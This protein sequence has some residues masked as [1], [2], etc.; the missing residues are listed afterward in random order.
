MD[1]DEHPY[2]ELSSRTLLLEG[3]TEVPQEAP[4]CLEITEAGPAH[5]VLV[6]FVERWTTG[7]ISY[8]P[9]QLHAQQRAFLFPA[10]HKV[11]PGDQVVV[12]PSIADSVLEVGVSVQ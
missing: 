3:I 7:D 1:I 9:G 10:S 6:W 12:R 8:G 5:C 4:I 2:T 11:Q